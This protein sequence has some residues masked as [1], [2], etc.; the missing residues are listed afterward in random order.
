VGFR[1]AAIVCLVLLA[2]GVASATPDLFP[3]EERIQEAILRL[4]RAATALNE[5]RAAQRL[6]LTFRV[7]TR[8][9][10]DLHDQKL[11]FGEVAVVLALA[12]AARTP[13]DRILG[14]WAS[15]RLD[16]SEIAERLR[17]DA[18][19]LLARLE[20]VRRELVSPATHAAR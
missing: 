18:S 10:A 19:A 15:A 6:A 8:T 5:A 3:V 16:W 17:I 20:A 9:V 13:A 12:E 11:D 7:P 2:A 14:L 4:D 1:A